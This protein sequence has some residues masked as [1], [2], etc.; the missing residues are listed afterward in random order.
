MSPSSNQRKEAASSEDDARRA[1]EKA[2]EQAARERLH[3]EF[4][5]TYCFSRV[6]CHFSAGRL[7]LRGTVPSFYLHQV[8]T[9]RL[10]GLSGVEEIDNQV[11]VISAYGLSSVRPETAT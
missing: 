4:P 3:G 5:F 7:V 8:L 1:A 11:D 9:K 6:T 10:R 2:V